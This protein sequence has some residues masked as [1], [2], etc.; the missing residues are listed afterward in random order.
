MVSVVGS[1]MNILIVLFQSVT[2]AVTT[3]LM[4]NMEQ[5]K[6]R[7][8]RLCSVLLAGVAG[9]IAIGIILLG[10]EIIWIFGGS[11]YKE[12]IILLPGMAF[13]IFL[14]IVTTLFT[15]ILTYEKSVFKT[16]VITSVAGVAAV[17]A[18]VVMLSSHGYAVLP[19][20]NVIAFACVEYGHAAGASI[21]KRPSAQ[22]SKYLPPGFSYFEKPIY[23][24]TTSGRLRLST[25]RAICF[26]PSDMQGLSTTAPCFAATRV[27][28]RRSSYS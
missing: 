28:S 12:S 6:Y 21:N 2:G 5:G 16:A 15:I 20:I 11:K 8:V 18:K 9:L 25:S 13:A 27:D 7:E 17:I 23:F 4:D 22:A 19:M 10:P 1:I 24:R 14:Q 3:W 26:S